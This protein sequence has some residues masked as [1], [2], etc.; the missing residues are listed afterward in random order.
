MRRASISA[1]IPLFMLLQG[2]PV[3]GGGSDFGCSANT[4]CPNAYVCDTAGECQLPECTDDLQCGP[5]ERCVNS[6]CLPDTDACGARFLALHLLQA[7][8]VMRLPHAASPASDHVTVSIGV[9]A[10]EDFAHARD[11]PPLQH[12]QVSALVAAA[13]QALYA[14]KGGGRHQ[15]RF[16]AVHELGMPERAVDLRLHAEELAASLP[17][18]ELTPS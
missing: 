6:L 3:W 7:V 12:L 11:T 1:L 10:Y 16:L 4:D 2:C 13:D 15:A 17:L 8:D 18:P 9:S 5:L 14:A